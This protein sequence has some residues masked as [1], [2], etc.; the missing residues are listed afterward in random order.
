MTLVIICLDQR[1][2]SVEVGIKSEGR[3]YFVTDMIFLVSAYFS[4]SNV[5]PNRK[6]FTALI[7]RS[8]HDEIKAEL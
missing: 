2:Q 7:I 3:E 4:L 1:N 8:Y 5:L 6:G